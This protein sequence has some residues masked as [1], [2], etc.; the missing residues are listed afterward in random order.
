MPSFLLKIWRIDR[1][2]LFELTWDRVRTL[3]ATLT[4]P[5][6]LTTLYQQWQ[7]AYI[8]FYRSYRSTVRARPGISLSLPQHKKDWRAKLVEAEAKFLAE[9]HYWLNHAELVEIRREIAQAAAQSNRVDIFI[10]CDSLEMAK[11]PWESWQIGTEFGITNPIRIVRTAANLRAGQKKPVHR[12][13]SRILVILGDDTGL[14]FQDERKAIQALSRIAEV[15]FVGWQV[16]Q[17]CD[18]LKMTICNAI[19]DRR[20]WDILCFLGHSNETKITGGELGIAP[21]T[22]IFISEIAQYL[23]VAQER[24]LQFAVFNSCNGLNIAESLLNLGLSHVAVMREPIH[25]EVAK[26]FLIQFLR[27]LAEYQNVQEAMLAACQ[28]LKLENNLTIPS[29]YLIPS[30][31]SYPEVEPFRLKRIGWRHRLQQLQPNRFDAIALGTFALISSLLPL[32]SWLIDQRQAVQAVYRH[33]TAQSMEAQTPPVLLVQVD[34]ASLQ[35][36]RVEIIN[37]NLDRTYLAKLVNRVSALNASIVGID[38]LLFRHQPSGDRVL[39]QALQTAV[40]QKGTQFILAAT[41]ENFQSTPKWVLALPEIANPKW[42]I[43]GDMDLLGDP[44]FY[45]RVI[46]DTDAE[47]EVLPMAYQ[48]VLTQQRTG[49]P[50]R[51]DER[52]RLHPVSQFA[53]AIGQMWLRPLID[54]STPKEQVYQ[55][56][57]AWKLLKQSEPAKIRQPLVLISPGGN[58]DAGVKPGEDNFISPMAL[59]YWRGTVTSKMTGGEVH[60][61]LVHNLLHHRLIIPIPD[62]WMIGVAGLFSK[63]MVIW[64]T[65]RKTK[66]RS[67]LSA[68]LLVVPIVYTAASLQS[69]LSFAILLPWLFPTLIYCTYLLPFILKRD[70]HA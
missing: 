6:T 22:S 5:E 51:W 58:V 27:H 70:Q 25:N 35:N 50:Y 11:L 46:G 41:L 54:F 19:A 49:M 15:E 21:K 12:Q 28:F 40:T 43:D 2:C 55:A 59:N 20:G 60:A 37:Q 36:D 62:L 52:T 24:G 8:N 31:F 57:P 45:A 56:I 23:Q 44:A 32:Q 14:D 9:F 17:A 38:Y 30:L 29:A 63:G 53:A 42:R 69:Y 33:T 1:T 3:N 67:R 4:Y 64:L 61:Y 66:S 39:A 34:E 26:E 65:G 18:D 47:T 68:Y 7:E 13:R 16:G 10:R 48:L